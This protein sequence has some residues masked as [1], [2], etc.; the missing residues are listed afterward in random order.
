MTT[1]PVLTS[2]LFVKLGDQYI[3][4]SY[5][6]YLRPFADSTSPCKQSVCVD[7]GPGTKAFNWQPEKVADVEWL[8]KACQ[9]LRPGE[10]PPQPKVLVSELEVFRAEPIRDAAPPRPARQPR[11]R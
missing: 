2:P 4:L 5:V 3:N 10:L 8:L 9:V 11:A 1:T 6:H 7:M